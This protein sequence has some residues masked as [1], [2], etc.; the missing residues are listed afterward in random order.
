MK[1]ERDVIESSN[2]YDTLECRLSDGWE[3]ERIE[4]TKKR[5]GF[6]RRNESI[7]KIFYLKRDVIETEIKIEVTAYV[8][9]YNIK[10]C[11]I[12][13]FDIADNVKKELIKKGFNK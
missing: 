3:V 9:A 13:V 5:S 4:T 12:D 10:L 8:P 11:D 6:I 2:E 1:F 7:I